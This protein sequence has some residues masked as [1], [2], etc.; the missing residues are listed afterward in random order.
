MPIIKATAKDEKIGIPLS[1]FAEGKTMLVVRT[2][3]LENDI[4]IIKKED[5]YHAIYL[6]CTHEGVGLTPTSQ[7]IVCTAHGSVFDFDGNVLKEPALKP[8]K[9]FKTSVIDNNLII[10]LT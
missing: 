9:K 1:S 5:N 7:K 8:L 2:A 10:S 4:L 6:Q 3:Q